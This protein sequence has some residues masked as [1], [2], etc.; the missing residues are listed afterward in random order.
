MGEYLGSVPRQGFV[1]LKSFSWQ[2][3]L[4]G[5]STTMRVIVD[6]ILKKKPFIMPEYQELQTG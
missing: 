2:Q 1:Q 6:G 3:L 5:N 4:P